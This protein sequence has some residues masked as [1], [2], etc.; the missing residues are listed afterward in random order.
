MGVLVRATHH[1]G[2]VVYVCK[3]ICLFLGG[4]FHCNISVPGSDCV[5]NPWC[6]SAWSTKWSEIHVHSKGRIFKAQTTQGP[7]YKAP[8]EMNEIPSSLCHS[9]V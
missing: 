9:S 4:V 5:S 1:L 2:P 7:V 8:N 6:H 3:M